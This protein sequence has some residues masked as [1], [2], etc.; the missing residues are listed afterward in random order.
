VN[1]L[2]PIDSAA[3]ITDVLRLAENPIFRLLS[4]GAFNP[5]ANPLGFDSGMLAPGQSY[6]RRFTRP[7]IYAYTDGAGRAGQVVVTNY[8]LLLPVVKR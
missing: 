6:Q 2:A 5:L 3:V 7:G 8:R 1:W 4:S